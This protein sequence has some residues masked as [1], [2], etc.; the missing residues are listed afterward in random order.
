MVILLTNDDGYRAEGIQTLFTV[1]SSAHDVYM[2][3]PSTER[4]ACS[5]ALTMRHHLE[6][7]KISDR[8]YSLSG[9]PADCVNTGFFGKFLPEFDLVISGINHGPNLGDDIHYSGTVAGA[10]TS[11][12]NGKSGIAV[13]LCGELTSQRF[14]DGAHYILDFLAANEKAFAAKQ[15]FLNINYP[16]CD[17]ELLKGSQFC[18]LDKRHYHNHFT[19]TQIDAETQ[20]LKLEGIANSERVKGSDVDAVSENYIAITPLTI[21]ASDYG[22]LKSCDG[23]SIPPPA[24]QEWQ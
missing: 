21:D 16:D 4:S 13:S 2:I 18:F 7:K 20:H 22:L 10:R 6:L 15:H 14:L 5:N 8:V 12:I 19:V 9:Y 17:S 11:V 3:A 1:L 24:V 23:L